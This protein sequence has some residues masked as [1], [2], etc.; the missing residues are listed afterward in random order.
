MVSRDHWQA[1]LL[2]CGRVLENQMRALQA[3]AIHLPVQLQQQKITQPKD[4]KFDARRARIDR[5]Q[6]WWARLHEATSFIKPSARLV[7][8]E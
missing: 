1:F 4:S 2:I 3:N 5:Q 6:A 7:D 8:R